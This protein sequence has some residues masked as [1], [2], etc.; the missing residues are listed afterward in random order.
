MGTDHCF[1]VDAHSRSP[2]CVLIFGNLKYAGLK[3]SLVGTTL[4]LG[5]WTSQSIHGF[6]QDDYMAV[7]ASLGTYCF[8]F[9]QECFLIRLSLTGVAQAVFILLLSFSFA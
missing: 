7:Y 6:K 2:R 3:S 9:R 5:F 1:I 4:F 8:T